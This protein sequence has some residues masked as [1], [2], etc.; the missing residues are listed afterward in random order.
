MSAL[1]RLNLPQNWPLIGAGIVV[2][3]ALS[4]FSGAPF[5]F[6]ETIPFDRQSTIN[7]AELLFQYGGFPLARFLIIIFIAGI[8]F[9]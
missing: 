9:S 3:G 2:I 6:S 7:Y 4:I 1:N 5:K 8:L